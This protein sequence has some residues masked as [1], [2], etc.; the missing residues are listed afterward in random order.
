MISRILSF[1]G[2]F[3]LQQK[4]CN[5]YAN[6]RAEFSDYLAHGP[7]KILDIGCS[8]GACGQAVFDTTR[9]CYIG[10]DVTKS[11]IDYAKRSYDRGHY[12][13]MD[14]RSLSFESESFDVVSFNGVLHH[15]D[16]D[17]AA[18]SLAEAGRVIKSTGC[19]LIAEP[20]FTPNDLLSN[21]FLSIDRG[22]FI[23][24]TSQYEALLNLFHIERKRYF[25]FSLHRFLS[26]V[27]RRVACE[28]ELAPPI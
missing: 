23:R 22:K 26:L 6:V 10:I 11:Y 12:L 27:A 25:S 20:V 21:I 5:N 9:D 7:L 16:D 15:M 18:K 3:H 17:M 19:L 14:A 24:E 1:P 13:N 28:T 8:T 4:L 2:V